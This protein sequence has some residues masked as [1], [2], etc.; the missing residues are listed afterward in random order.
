[1]STDSRSVS[2]T[3]NPIISFGNPRELPST[4]RERVRWLFTKDGYPSLIAIVVGFLVLLSSK[5]LTE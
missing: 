3:L 1:M 5:I 4:L 2:G